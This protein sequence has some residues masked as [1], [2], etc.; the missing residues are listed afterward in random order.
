MES[1]PVHIALLGTVQQIQDERRRVP[2]LV[3]A[4]VLI[5]SVPWVQVDRRQAPAP[6]AGIEMM[7]RSGAEEGEPI[8][9][10]PHEAVPVPAQRGGAPSARAFV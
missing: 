7:G 6:A 5:I 2:V 1:T 9:P 8:V 3:P 4:G 10:L